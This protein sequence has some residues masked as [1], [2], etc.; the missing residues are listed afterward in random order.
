MDNLY[1]FG[2]IEVMDLSHMGRMSYVRAKKIKK[3][4]YGG[5]PWRFPTEKEILY[6]MSLK[7]DYNISAFKY[8]YYY[9]S[10]SMYESHV[11]VYGLLMDK[12][13]FR[14]F[15]APVVNA[16]GHLMLVRDL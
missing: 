3:E 5:R 12:N 9:S 8:G 15:H 10:V 16:I 6:A 13:R 2:L 14:R 1:N 11:M 4:V 7:V